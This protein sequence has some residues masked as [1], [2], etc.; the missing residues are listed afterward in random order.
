MSHMKDVPQQT[1]DLPVPVKSKGHRWLPSLVW[2]IPV[3]AACIGISL[4]VKTLLER[5]PEID[6]YFQ[7]AEGLE[8][9]KT[10]V[11]YKDVSIGTVHTIRLS[12]D[13]KRVIAKVQLTKD[14]ASFAVKDTRFWVVRPRVGTSGI[15]GLGTLLSGAYIAADAGASEE[16]TDAFVGLET[17]PLVTRDDS[18]RQF[19]L[20]AADMGSLDIGTPVY[21]RHINVG[22]VT[23]FHLDEDGKGVTLRIFVNAPYDKFVGM[24]TRFWHASGIDLQMDAGGFQIKTQSLAT[25]VQ[26]GISFQAPEGIT[27][28]EAKENSQF[29][30]VENQAE[31]FR[32]PDVAAQSVLM[33]F[34][35]SVRGLSPGAPVDFRGIVL[36][37][38]KSIGIEYDPKQ[39]KI[40]MPVLVDLYPERLRSIDK[41]THRIFDKKVDSAASMTR[42]ESLVK[43]GL[44]G[45]LQSGSL[46]TGQRFIAL[47]FFPKAAPAKLVKDGDVYVLPTIPG[48]LDAMGNQLTDILDKMSKVP[49]DKIGAD[50]SKTLVTLNQSLGEAEKLAARL[51]NDIAPEIRLM[52]QDARSTLKSADRALSEQSPVQQDL[53]DTL[54]EVS[55]A[56]ASIRVVTDYLQQ[57]PEALV[58]GK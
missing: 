5:G 55:R 51:N 25:I 42:V 32:H 49:F 15:S 45:Q 18:G 54:Q 3:V 40:L 10:Q 44:R 16:K 2:I 41:S 28:P 50:L 36:G 12:K 47:D 35:Q 58:M 29:Q 37:E 57:H 33:Y 31:A 1:Q 9:G 38:V 34:D 43:Y 39:Q 53:R 23:A 46:L 24:N 7:T 19:V 52:M 14:A 17:P 27:G 26:G 6:I 21:Y 48:S 56:A 11:K 13:K 8:A 4:V 20:R 22:N 30:L